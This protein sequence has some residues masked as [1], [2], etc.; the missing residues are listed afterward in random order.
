[1]AILKSLN[2]WSE[3]PALGGGAKLADFC[4]LCHKPLSFPAVYWLGGS[5][6]NPP[7]DGAEVW[8]HPQ[9]AKSLSARLLRDAKELED[10][11]GAADEWLRCWKQQNE[12][13]A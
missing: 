6:D 7:S 4:F 5:L 1:M 9:C 8:L 3:A 10:G 11:K 2:D 12:R 13:G